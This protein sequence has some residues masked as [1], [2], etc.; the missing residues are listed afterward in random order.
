MINIKIFKRFS[1]FRIQVQNELKEGETEK[2]NSKD[3]E[4]QKTF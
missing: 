1:T 2:Y 3:Y 4:K